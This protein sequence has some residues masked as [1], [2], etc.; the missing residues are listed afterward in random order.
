MSTTIRQINID[1]LQIGM[2][3]TELEN[4]WVPDKNFSRKGLINRV[5]VIEQIRA[6]GVEELY[7]DIGRGKDIE[8]ISP[9]SQPTPSQSSFQEHLLKASLCLSQR[10]L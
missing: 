8:P 1:Q 5:E 2:F 7:I 9:V 10:Y 6:L 4:H 3:I